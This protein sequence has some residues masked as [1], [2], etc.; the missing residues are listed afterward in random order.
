MK[1]IIAFMKHRGEHLPKAPRQ[2][3]LRIVLIAPFVLQ[4][5]AAVSLVGYL[6]F[7]DGQQAINNLAKKLQQEVGAR[8]DQ[9]LST[10]LALP[11]QIN[12]LTLDAI[13]RGILDPQDLETAGRYF[14]KQSQIF[15]Q[16][17]YLGY[18]L[19]D[20]AAVGA[21]RWLPNRGVVITHQLGGSLKNSTYA[22]DAR[23]NRT[24]LVYEADYNSIDDPWY[25]GTAKAGKPIWSRIYIA[26]G[27]GDY[28]AASANVPFYDKSHQ[29]LGVLNIDLLLS[30]ISTF[31]H[32]IRLSP[33]SKVLIIERDGMLIG[34]SGDRP[35]FQTINNQIERLSIVNHSDPMLRAIAQ[36]TQKQF[37]DFK[38]IQNTQDLEFQFNG[39]RQF[40]HVKPWQDKYGLDWLVIVTMP[41]SDFMAEINAN[42]RKT[43]FLCLVCLIAATVLGLFTTRWLMQPILHL[44]KASQAITQGNLNQEIEPSSIREL[45]NLSQSFNQ[46]AAQLRSSFLIL[47]QVNVE[48]EDRV[49]ER[50]LDLQNALSDLSRT[51]TQMVQSEKMSALGKMVAGV[52]HE[53]NN[54]VNFIH[55]NLTYIEEYSRGMLHLIKLYH[56]HFPQPPAEIQAERSALDIEFLETDLTS[57]LQSMNMGTTRIKDIVLSLRN[58]S[59]LDQTQVK[60]VDIHEGI[61]S[62]LLFLD[63]RLKATSNRPEILVV[64]K[65]GV[66]PKLECYAGELNQVFM[67]LLTNAIDAI[68]EQNLKQNSQTIPEK[69]NEITICT[70]AVDRNLQI[71]IADN[72]CGI[73]EPIQQQIFNPFFTTKP[74]GKGT[75]MGLSI[76][77]Q[78]ICDKHRG[79]LT[80]SSIAGEGTEFVIKIPMLQQIGELK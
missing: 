34:S 17:S 24:Q 62:T 79:Q 61:N 43:I 65:Y 73:P 67:Y 2:I 58:F 38:S 59:R 14:W 1:F 64:K 41:E 50:T 63:H 69:S 33:S 54:P 49:E 72:G 71:A 7:K 10:Y 42:T 22:T 53:I 5:F 52:A 48:L 35:I 39:Q 30:D 19:K 27:F 76:S 25:T 56:Q 44:G 55:G 6:S 75:G 32:Q 68:E 15:K 4:I 16:F 77:Y 46:M 37:R 9:N 13:D 40:V 23:G 60:S 80:C 51:Q 74:I 8:V 70:S 18:V 26:E 29:L 36:A 78:I 28:V 47:E 21:G 12:Q 57:I 31:L 45:N 20:N 11:H 66:L 3:P